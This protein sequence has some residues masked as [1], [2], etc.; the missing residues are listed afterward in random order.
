MIKILTGTLADL[1]IEEW[2]DYL[3]DDDVFGCGF[4]DGNMGDGR[5]GGSEIIPFVDDDNGFTADDK[6]T[7]EFI[8]SD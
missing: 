7:R 6:L 2:C 4:G 1:V 5:G 8:A 3:G